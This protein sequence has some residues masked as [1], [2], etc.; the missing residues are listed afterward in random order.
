[1]REKLNY[2]LQVTFELI[3]R[4]FESVF[5]QNVI[6]VSGKH[7]SDCIWPNLEVNESLETRCFL[8]SKRLIAFKA[9][10][11]N[12]VEIVLHFQEVINNLT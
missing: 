4:C 9:K 7:F 12:M 5:T 2:F 1:M 3:W 6:R 8:N 11:K 10:F